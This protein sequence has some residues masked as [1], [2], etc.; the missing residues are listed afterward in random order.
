MTPLFQLSHLTK[1]T[2]IA[3][4]SLQI[5][6]HRETIIKESCNDFKLMA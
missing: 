4:L 1:V 5:L 3:L 2:L 6:R